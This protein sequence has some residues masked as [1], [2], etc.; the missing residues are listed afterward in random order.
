[1]EDLATL[2]K[3]KAGTHAENLF[4]RAAIVFAVIA[5]DHFIDLYLKRISVEDA[6]DKVQKQI[7]ELRRNRKIGSLIAA[8]WFVV[9]DYYTR[10][11]FLPGVPP[12]SELKKLV[13]RRNNLVHIYEKQLRSRRKTGEPLLLREMSWKTAEE[14]CT[15][16]KNMIRAFYQMAHKSPPDWIEVPD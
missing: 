1:V 14:A 3:N 7:K 15:T 11:R 4:T 9:S 6:K 2:A 12:F 8:K 13:K 10:N 5:L 16:A